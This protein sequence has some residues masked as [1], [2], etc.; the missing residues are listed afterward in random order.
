MTGFSADW[1]LPLPSDFETLIQ[2]CLEIL[3]NG[4]AGG[5]EDVRRPLSDRLPSAWESNNYG[6]DTDQKNT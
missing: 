4:K 1:A 6:F 3:I 2:V 5:F